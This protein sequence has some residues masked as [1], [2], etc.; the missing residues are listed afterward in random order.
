MA[1]TI[2]YARLIPDTPPEGLTDWVMSQGKLN[3]EYLIYKAGRGYDPLEDAWK[4][5]VE[6]TCTACGRTFM[7]EKVSA[8]GCHNSYAPAPFG[9]V[10]PRMNE[11][12]ISGNSTF[13]PI[14]EQK[15]ETVHIGQMPCGIT[16]NEYTAVISRLPVEGKQD[17][18][19]LTDWQTS[20]WIDKQGISHFRNCVYTAWVVEEKKIVRLMG[21]TR[22]SQ[23]ICMHR[24]EQ[25]KTMLD[26]F[27]EYQLLYPWEPALLEGTTV[28]NCKLDIFIAAGGRYLV[29]YLA[30]WRRHPNIENLVMQGWSKL[31]D[32]LIAA[33]RTSGSYYSTNRGIPQLRS[34]DWKEKKPHLMLRMTKA[35]FREYAGISA[36]QFKLLAWARGKGIKVSCRGDIQTLYQKSGY[37]CEQVLELVGTEEF[38]KAIRYLGGTGREFYMLR[39]YW[40]MAQ[41]LDMDLNHA[42]VRWPKDLRKAHDLVMEQ[43][44][45]KEDAVLADRFEARAEELAC[46]S[47]RWDGILIRPCNTEK[48]MRQEGTALSHCVARYA[49]DHASGKTAIFFIRK[50]TEPDKSWFTLE[51]DE[52]T[53]V[54]RQNRGKCNC[55]R[56]PEVTAFEEAWLEHIKQVAAKPRKR[57]EQKTA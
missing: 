35:E 37:I 56:T 26:D 30:V 9:W 10:H 55:A 3:K 14:C 42:Q 7:A 51:L 12:V 49:K 47:W 57:K 25:R 17:R 13:C 27:G 54:V 43:Q 15:G 33:N 22:N 2:N 21:Y 39:D 36:E 16:Q 29:S 24:P 31:I 41:A 48:E 45:E 20:R 28:E 5:A 34:I 23:H 50:E 1:E 38:W 46:M 53:M 40:K 52:K 6:V 18:L 32:D 4:A 8:G 11:S 19:L 44:K